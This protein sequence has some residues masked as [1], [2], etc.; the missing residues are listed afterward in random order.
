MNY[1]AQMDAAIQSKDAVESQILHLPG[2]NAIDVG[3]KYVN[4]EMT[5]QLAIRDWFVG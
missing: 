2:V 5:D 4:G 1:T 3:F